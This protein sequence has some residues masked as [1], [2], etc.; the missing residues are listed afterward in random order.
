[1]VLYI[2]SARHE[3]AVVHGVAEEYFESSCEDCVR[4][5]LHTMNDI[6]KHTGLWM[7]ATTKRLPSGK[8]TAGDEDVIVISNSEETV[9]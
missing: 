3:E 1:M 2:A 5:L 4:A 8:V 9:Q 6:K 7:A